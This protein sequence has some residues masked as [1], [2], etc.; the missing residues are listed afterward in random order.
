MS[1]FFFN[2]V[3][4]TRETLYSPLSTGGRSS[5]VY[6]ELSARKENELLFP[7]VHISEYVHLGGIA[8]GQK[9]SSCL[10]SYLIGLYASFSEM[11]WCFYF[12]RSLWNLKLKLLETSRDCVTESS[13]NVE[14][15]VASGEKQ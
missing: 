8:F 1:L 6:W 7:S 9:M 15:A 12:C 14:C 5:V 13:G 2:S 4:I 3:S 10:V 11:L